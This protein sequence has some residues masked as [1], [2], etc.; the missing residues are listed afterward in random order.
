MC[1]LDILRIG[2]IACG[3]DDGGLRMFEGQVVVHL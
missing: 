2:A 3:G 1:L